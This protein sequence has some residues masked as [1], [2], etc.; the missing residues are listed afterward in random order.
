MK[1]SGEAEGVQWF[2]SPD[3]RKRVPV[4]RT[5]DTKLDY[6]S[7]VLSQINYCR[8]A[9]LFGYR[10]YGTQVVLLLQMI[11]EEDHDPRFLE[12]I[13]DAVIMTDRPTGRY[14]GFGG[15]TREVI[16]K[17]VTYDYHRLYRACIN[18]LKRRGAF[19][20][21]TKV[22]AIWAEEDVPEE[23]ENSAEPSDES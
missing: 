9:A 12:D 1:L 7:A 3:E 6:K 8:Y 10:A 11:P 13:K 16:A 17:D 23:A 21:T 2:Y 4:K 5:I 18:L 19:W 15:E 20:E 22:E 14:M